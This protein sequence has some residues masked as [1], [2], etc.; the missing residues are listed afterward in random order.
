MAAGTGAE[1]SINFCIASPCLLSTLARLVLTDGVSSFHR[2]VRATCEPSDHSIWEQKR[3]LG[4]WM[5]QV[6]L[7]C[8]H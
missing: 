8:S 5:P 7:L 3:E 6:M 2:L 4:L 1:D